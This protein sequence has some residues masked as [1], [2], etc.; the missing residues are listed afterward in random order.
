MNPLT[1]TR[2]TLTSCLGAGLQAH[3]DALRDRRS[4]LTPCAFETARLDTWVGQVPDQQLAPV[5]VSLPRYDCRNNRL[6]HLA[7]AQDGFDD[8][9]AEARSRYGAKLQK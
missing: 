6:A 4:G 2:Y 5:P 7:L 1:L 9:V 8:A 3:V